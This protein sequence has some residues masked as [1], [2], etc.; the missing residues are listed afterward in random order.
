VRKRIEELKVL[1][2][3]KRIL[4]GVDRLDYIKGIP[5]KL[6]AFEVFLDSHPEFIGKVIERDS[7]SLL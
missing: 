5:Q 1:F 4:M 3:G 7:C 2:Q 6:R